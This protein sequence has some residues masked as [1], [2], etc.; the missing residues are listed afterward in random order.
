LAVVLVCCAG[1]IVAPAQETTMSASEQALR[2][3]LRSYQEAFNRHDA[4]KVAEHWADNA[5]YQSD[6]GESVTGRAAIQEVFAGKFAAEPDAR[7]QSKL[8]R[9]RFVAP[10]VAIIEGEAFVAG[11]EELTDATHFR[12]IVVQQDGAWK[13]NE[14]TE[15][16]AP[17]ETVGRHYEQLKELEWMVG[18]WVD[19]SDVSTAET[20]CQWAKNKNFLTRSFKVSAPGVETLEGT[21]VIGWDP[22]AGT[23]RSWVFDSDGGFM[24]ATWTR[25]GNTW[26]VQSE[27]YLEDGTTVS[28]VQVYTQI[29]HDSFRWRSFGRRV[30]NEFAPNIPETLVVRKTS[31]SPGDSAPNSPPGETP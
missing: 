13:I 24:Q 18:E 15:V 1:G 7:L 16:G 28:S 6:A 20:V 8:N 14:V 19:E 2:A 10:N 21:Q 29:D 5:E 27:G 17:T 3:M 23:I 11:I 31:A 30:G 12:A 9:I 26:T 25:S 4:A 22:V